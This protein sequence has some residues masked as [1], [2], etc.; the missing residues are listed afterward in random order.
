MGERGERSNLKV[1]CIKYFSNTLFFV[2]FRFRSWY[3]WE[4]K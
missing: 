2:V 4:G 1:L 3:F